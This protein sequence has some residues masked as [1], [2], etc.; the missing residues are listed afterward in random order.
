MSENIRINTTLFQAYQKE[1]DAQ[2]IP[3]HEL[4]EIA[5]SEYLKIKS[6]R[7]LFEKAK[8]DSFREREEVYRRLAQ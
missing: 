1:A 5:M 6:R 4:A 2:G 8:A 7:A 3:V